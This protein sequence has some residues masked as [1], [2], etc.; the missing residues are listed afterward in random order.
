MRLRLSV[1]V[2]LLCFGC[3]WAHALDRTAPADVDGN[4]PAPGPQA[5][6]WNVGGGATRGGGPIIFNDQAA[7]LA[8]AGPAA[9]ETFETD[10]TTAGC[11]SAGVLVLVPGAFTATSNIPAL[12]LLEV[13]CFGNHDTTPDGRKYL[14]ADPDISGVSAD[15]MFEFNQPLTA[16]GLFLIDLDFANLEVTI[17]GVAYPVLQNGD[18]GESYFGIVG[19]A[20]FTTVTFQIVTAFDS[21]YSFDDVTYGVSPPLSAEEPTLEPRSWSGVKSRYR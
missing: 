11:D 14:G 6:G 12:K 21:H 3:S 5:P 16:L 1:L 7:F 2:T 13:P 10:S 17:D 19:A 18:G 9:T 4:A 8:A 20:P 15:V